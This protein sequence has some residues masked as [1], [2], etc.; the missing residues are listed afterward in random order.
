MRLALCLLYANLVS[1][2][3]K[4]LKKLSLWSKDVTGVRFHL[5]CKRC[6]PWFYWYCNNQLNFAALAAA[7]AK[8]SKKFVWQLLTFEVKKWFQ[9][10][11]FRWSMV[12]SHTLWWFD[13]FWNEPYFV[14]HSKSM[15]CSL[16]LKQLLTVLTPSRRDNLM[17]KSKFKFNGFTTSDRGLARSF[18]G[19]WNSN[20]VSKD[21]YIATELSFTVYA[22]LKFSLNV[23]QYWPQ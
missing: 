13:N 4:H 15:P 19:P 10:E 11:Y 7:Y 16:I 6:C 3:L 2:W 12:D 18:K 17:C 1:D 21:S 8:H 20:R 9:Y 14:L 23:R 5:N 22:A